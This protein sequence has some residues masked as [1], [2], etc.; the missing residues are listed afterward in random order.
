MGAEKET[1]G[2]AFATAPDKAIGSSSSRLVSSFDV[3]NLPL[4][5]LE[6]FLSRLKLPSSDPLELLIAKAGVANNC[7]MGMGGQLGTSSNDYCRNGSILPLPFSLPPVG[8]VKS[9]LDHEK[10]SKLGRASQ[11]RWVTGG[12]ST[13]SRSSRGLAGSSGLSHKEEPEVTGGESVST[14]ERKSSSG[15]RTRKYERTEDLSRKQDCMQF[16]SPDG[17]QTPSPPQETGSAVASKGSLASDEAREVE[18]AV[19]LSSNWQAQDLMEIDLRKPLTG[20]VTPLVDNTIETEDVMLSVPTTQMQQAVSADVVRWLDVQ[21]PAAFGEPSLKML[22]GK[23]EENSTKEARK[24]LGEGP[25]SLTGKEQ[26][27]PVLEVKVREVNQS[28]IPTDPSTSYIGSFIF[29]FAS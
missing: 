28:V 1:S 12:T 25:S 4:Y 9:E 13:P 17:P 21:M 8:P 22:T 5:S 7:T 2:S 10:G 3:D 11:Q 23:E 18:N 26:G 27:P 29:L 19:R 16:C 15:R 20:A 6:E 14:G 24:E